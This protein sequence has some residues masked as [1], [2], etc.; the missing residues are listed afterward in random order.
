MAKKIL[1]CYPSC[2]MNSTF[3]DR[4]VELL[5][6]H[7]EVV[8]L[9][10]DPQDRLF[11]FR[12]L[13]HLRDKDI[14]FVWFGGKYAFEIWLACK[15]LRKKLV[16]VAG[17]Y[18]AIYLPEIEHG[19]KYENKGWRR[20]YFAFR[21]A[22]KVLA[23]SN[24]LRESLE[25]ECG[26]VKNVAVLYHGFGAN[27]FRLPSW[28]KEA[29]VLTVC[30]VNWRNIRRKGLNTFISAA[31]KLPDVNFALVGGGKGGALE[32]LKSI[33]PPNVLFTGSCSVQET[34]EIMKRAKVYVQISDVE[35]FGC[36]LAEAMLCGCV[37]VATK[38]GALPE[39]AGGEAFYVEYGD[40]EG[41]VRAIG[42]ALKVPSGAK[43]RERI[44]KRFNLGERERA[45]VRILNGVSKQ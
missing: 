38:R 19:L 1:F 14:C 28:E 30:H 20:A 31:A 43:F 44:I 26:A 8:V 23:V 32:Y 12:S 27:P 6:R 39:V 40:I 18:D 15:L 25:R 3:I 21:H 7:Y 37:P 29:L 10:W 17:G 45:L 41:T 36:A 33:A 34:K 24:W 22:D 9:H 5:K 16:I 35:S 13:K 11:F 42:E 2:E 4:D